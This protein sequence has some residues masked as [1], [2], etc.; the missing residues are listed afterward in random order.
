[1]GA[2]A[3]RAFGLKA[4]AWL[5]PP[6]RQEKRTALSFPYDGRCRA[7]RYSRPGDV[8]GNHAVARL[9]NKFRRTHNRRRSRHADQKSIE[10]MIHDQSSTIGPGT[11]IN[12]LVFAQIDQVVRCHG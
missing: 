5:Q 8:N 11:Y 12:P 6:V 10:W 3:A 9:Q 4:K 2:V 1:V 7:M